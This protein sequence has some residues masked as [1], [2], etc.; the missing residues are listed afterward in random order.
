MITFGKRMALMARYREWLEKK[1]AELGEPGKSVR[2]C[3]ESFLV[4]LDTNGLIDAD[5]VLNFI[6]QKDD[7]APTIDAEPVRH[8]YWE[9]SEVGEYHCTNC[10]VECDIDEFHK[11][12][13]NS[14]CGNCGARMDGGADNG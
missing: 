9:P 8:A 1:S 12:L 7:D 13:L 5:V 11:A 4:F 3:P 6:L 2:D 14:F 10:G